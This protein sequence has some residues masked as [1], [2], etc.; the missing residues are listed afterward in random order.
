LQQIG[1]AEAA[2]LSAELEALPG[3]PDPASA[4]P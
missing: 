3:T 4:S 1:A 2:D